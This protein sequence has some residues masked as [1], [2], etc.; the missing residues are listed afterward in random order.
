M[1]LSLSTTSFQAPV[2]SG[3]LLI[4]LGQED[5]ISNCSRSG[6][7]WTLEGISSLKGLSTLEQVP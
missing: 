1:P 6:S 7:D 3:F 2:A 5:I 4:F